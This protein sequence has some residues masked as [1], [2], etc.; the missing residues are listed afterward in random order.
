M[1]VLTEAVAASR[2]ASGHEEPE[3]K[4]AAE[5][6][7]GHLPIARGPEGP[8]ALHSERAVRLGAMPAPSAEALLNR[9]EVAEERGSAAWWAATRAR[10]C[11]G[12]SG[13][14]RSR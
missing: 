5:E 13:S 1:L 11:S 14:R 7:L 12:T 4:P 9:L 3:E 8:G 2:G 10:C 6:S